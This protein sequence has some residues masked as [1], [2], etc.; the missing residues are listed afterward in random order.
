MKGQTP[1]MDEFRN[2]KNKVEGCENQ[3]TMLK[4]LISQINTAL[5]N[6]PKDGSVKQDVGSNLEANGDLED[7][8]KK[9]KQDLDD[10]KKNND[11]RLGGI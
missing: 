7:E 9:L 8:L 3:I 5:K 4:K 2:L 6:I 1:T 10:Y 11:T